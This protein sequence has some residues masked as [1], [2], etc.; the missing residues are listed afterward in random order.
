MALIDHVYIADK[1][2][3]GDAGN[4]AEKGAALEE[5]VAETLCQLEGVGVIK[6]N[7]LD[8]AGSLEIDI[9]LYNHR[10]RDGLPFLPTHLIIECKNWQAPVN[11]ATLTVFTGKLR[12]FRVDFGILVAAN[13]ITGDAQDRTAAHAHLRSV[14]DRDGLAVIVITRAE[15]EALRD[16]EDLGLLMR[17]KYGDCIMGA[18]QF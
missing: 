10:L 14:Y 17:E 6:R 5:V 2:V 7:I 13:G 4:T 11:S 3:A 8:N 16:T 9:L 12:K 15:I 18:D 1:L